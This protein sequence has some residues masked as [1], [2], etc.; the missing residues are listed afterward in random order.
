MVPLGQPEAKDYEIGFAIVSRV[1]GQLELPF[2]S[3]VNLRS[4][5]RTLNGFGYKVTLTKIDVVAGS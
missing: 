2:F 1:P 5:A 3:K 4:A